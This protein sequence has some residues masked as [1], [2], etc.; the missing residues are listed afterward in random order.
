M[1]DHSVFAMLASGVMLGAASG[2]TPG[3]INTL[4]ISESLKHDKSAGVKVALSPLIT[5][6]FIVPFC[7]F[8]VNELSKID[9]MLGIITLMGAAFIIYLGGKDLFYTPVL[10]VE[11]QE[12]SRPLMRGI[13]ANFLTPH[14]FV[15]WLTIGGPIVSSAY[16][17]NGPSAILFIIAFY[18]LLVGLKVFLALFTYKFKKFLSGKSYKITLKIL[19]GFLLLFGIILLISG[20]Q[21]VSG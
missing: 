4:I 17:K 2:I 16:S 7:V 5:D 15:F 10:N 13:I 1:I 8:I 11:I 3:P 12:K 18:T 6:V 14:P 21:K 19:G 20:I 9:F